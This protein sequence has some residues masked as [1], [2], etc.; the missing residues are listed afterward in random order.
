ME[1]VTSVSFREND[2]TLKIVPLLS[3]PQPCRSDVILSCEHP[4]RCSFREEGGINGGREEKRERDGE[5]G[6]QRRRH[7]AT[8]GD[9]SEP[10]RE[11]PQLRLLSIPKNKNRTLV[12]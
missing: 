6:P 12:A 3:W 9:C 4:K 5:E 2:L 10:S 11:Q 7:P 1:R 8:M